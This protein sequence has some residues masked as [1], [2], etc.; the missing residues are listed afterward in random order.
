MELLRPVTMLHNMADLEPF[1]QSEWIVGQHPAADILHRPTQLTFIVTL[2]DD[3]R[4]LDPVSPTT[5][6]AHAVH[7]PD[8]FQI[9]PDPAIRRLARAAIWIWWGYYIAVWWPKQQ[10]A[11]TPIE[12]DEESRERPYFARLQVPKMNYRALINARAFY[13]VFELQD[14]YPLLLKRYRRAHIEAYQ[15][16]ATHPDAV[17]TLWAICDFA[18]TLPYCYDC[19]T[20]DTLWKA[21]FYTVARF[22][23]KLADL[24]DYCG[25]LAVRASRG[26]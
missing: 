26:S 13:A 20:A 3:I 5:V 22:R 24:A 9:P 4:P 15:R 10:P 16:P 18:N 7:I 17:F 8:G 12:M 1:D 21:E 2:A 23:A 19:L 6:A 11:P 25:R 14:R